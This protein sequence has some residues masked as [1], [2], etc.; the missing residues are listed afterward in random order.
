M[1]EEEK[2]TGKLKKG[3]KEI[4]KEIHKNTKI[5]KIDEEKREEKEK[6]TER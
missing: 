3:E 5:E 4:T 6:D 1:I 2:E